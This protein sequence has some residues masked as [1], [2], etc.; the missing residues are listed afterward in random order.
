KASY[1]E[2][3]LVII[4]TVIRTCLR[5][6]FRLTEVPD[7]TGFTVGDSDSDQ[8]LVTFRY[9]QRLPRRN[10]IFA[11]PIDSRLIPLPHS[12]RLQCYV[13]LTSC[14]SCGLTI[15]SIRYCPCSN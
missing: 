6:I 3:L 15:I 13:K 8:Q 11:I 10:I 4:N 1:A 7:K 14:P 2:F 5:I 12:R 9:K